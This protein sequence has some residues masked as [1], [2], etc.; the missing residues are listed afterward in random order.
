MSDRPKPHVSTPTP[1]PAPAAHAAARPPPRQPVSRRAALAAAPALALG[2]AF[3]AW[4]REAP[5]RAPA[6]FARLRWGLD[7]GRRLGDEADS[8]GPKSFALGPEGEVWVLDQVERRVLLLDRSARLAAT[9]PLARDT[10]DDVEHHG[11][12]LLLLDRLGRRTLSVLDRRGHVARELDLEGRGIPRA[13]LVTALLPRRDGVW[14]EVG[15]RHSVRVL[16]PSLSPCE[17]T[18]VVGRP[19]S[20]GRTL[21]ATLDGGGGVE[22][23]I[24]A[25]AEGTLTPT[26]RVVTASPARRV[27]WLDED[28]RG[29]AHLVV[30]ELARE[31]AHP[32][33]A[34][35]EQLSMVELDD[36]LRERARRTSPHVLSGYDQRVEVRVD[37]RGAVWQMAL[38]PEGVTLLAWPRSDA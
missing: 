20:G 31:A 34:V 33:R 35:C 9:V 28:R 16:G 32:F 10:Y 17:R 8:E 5:A 12:H 18:V 27:V 4:P 2:A 1:A 13:G 30:H 15:H 29:R 36:T 37:E 21:Q 19:I 11:G 14:L 38:G 23:A 26:T 7:V 24:G 6:P 25:Q 22:L 3:L